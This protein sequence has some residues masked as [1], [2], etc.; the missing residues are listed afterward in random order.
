MLAGAATELAELRE[1]LERSR[2]DG[3]TFALAWPAA[4]DACRLA[5]LERA[6]VED[7]RETW[8]RAYERQPPTPADRAAAR[9][10]AVFDGCGSQR[11]RY[12]ANAS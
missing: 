2:A 7:T 1:R 4:L 9:F 8:A 6:A 5:P 11:G 12:A 10:G 3:T